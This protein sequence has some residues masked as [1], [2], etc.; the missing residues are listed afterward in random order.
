MQTTAATK[1]LSYAGRNVLVTGADGFIGSHL[2]EALVKTGAHVTALSYYNSFGANG[3]LDD[4]ESETFG[5]IDIR[6]GDIRDERFV[7]GLV[8]G[9]NVVFHL[10]ALIGIPYSYIAPAS[11][12]DVNVKGSMNILNAS[13]DH[14]VARVVH[15]STSEV[16]GSARV[17]PITED[18][19]LQ[20]QSP[21]S[22][23]KIAADAMAEAYAK[24]FDL[25]VVILRPFNTFGPRQSE[26]AVIP[27]IIRQAL[28]PNCATIQIGDLTPQRDFN[29]VGDTVNAFIATGGATGLTHGAAYNAGSGNAVSIGDALAR[30]LAITGA[31][32]EVMHEGARVR[33]E[34]SEVRLLLADA[35]K[36]I[37]ATGWT[38]KIDFDSGLEQT[39]E[40]WR[41]HLNANAFRLGA[42]YAV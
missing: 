29:F 21:Y 24:S 19:P 8:A 32:K 17:T 11:Y 6:A 30:I 23:S 34:N 40:W 25:P 27:T 3:W 41:A 28:D 14:G 7:H 10:A 35:E 33:P 20:A 31:N 36:F 39:V 38:S 12:V 4:L 1:P 15:T 37:A 18:H 16:Y 9:Q 2:V 22:A 42:S 13:L 26:R 5:K